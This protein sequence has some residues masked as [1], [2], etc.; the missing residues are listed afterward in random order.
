ML[1]DI[2]Y[3]PIIQRL[4]KILNRSIVL[5]AK[6]DKPESSLVIPKINH[7]HDYSLKSVSA[8]EIFLLQIIALRQVI[9]ASR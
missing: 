1:R 5:F 3:A 7:R 4:R 6:H 9:V 2:S 8:V